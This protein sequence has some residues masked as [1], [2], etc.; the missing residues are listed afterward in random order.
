MKL[1]ENGDAAKTADGDLASTSTAVPEKSGDPVKKAV[2]APL[3][4]GVTMSREPSKNSEAPTS[5]VPPPSSQPSQ[6]KPLTN[7]VLPHA[8]ANVAPNSVVTPTSKCKGKEKEMN[9][10]SLPSPASLE[11]T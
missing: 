4:N 7:G 5:A 8:D 11:A 2:D 6:A 9:G 10:D 1:N 3:T